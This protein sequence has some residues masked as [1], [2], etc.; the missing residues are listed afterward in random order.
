MFI[1]DKVRLLDFRKIQAVAKTNEGQVKCKNCHPSGLLVSDLRSIFLERIMFA[2]LKQQRDAVSYYKYN[3]VYILA[4]RENKEIYVGYTTNGFHRI[5]N[6]DK[7]K[8]FWDV[9]LVFFDKENKLKPNEIAHLEYLLIDVVSRNEEYTM[10]NIEKPKGV[11]LTDES[12]CEKKAREI[13]S[14]MEFKDISFKERTLPPKQ[15]PLFP[16]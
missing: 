12:L 6:H 11:K 16:T 10:K 8:D 13:I 3:M 7:E 1:V 14:I 5:D 4:N 9:C 2:E 15:T